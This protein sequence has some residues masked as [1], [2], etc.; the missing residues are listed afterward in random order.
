MT[1]NKGGRP[2][3][4]KSAQKKPVNASF[5]PRSAAILKKK[6]NT[7]AYLDE[8][9]LRDNMQQIRLNKQPLDLLGYLTALGTWRMVFQADPRATF[10][11]Q[12]GG[13][14]ETYLDLAALGTHILH[15]WRPLPVLHPW[16]GSTGFDGKAFEPLETIAGSK[17]NRLASYRKCIEVARRTKAATGV[18]GKPDSKPPTKSAESR[19]EKHILLEAL[20][21]KMPDAYLEWLDAVVNLTDDGPLYNPILGTGGNIGRLDIQRRYM[22]SLLLVMDPETGGAT[23][24]AEGWL[25]HALEGTNAR[26]LPVGSM[27][28]YSPS[29]GTENHNPW[30][31]LMLCE[32][33]VMLGAAAQ[34]RYSALPSYAAP[35][36][37]PWIVDYNGAGT[38]HA[39]SEGEA[40]PWLPC[41]LEHLSAPQAAHVL[42]EGYAL[43]PAGKHPRDGVGFAM[44]A[45]SGKLEPGLDGLRRGGN[46]FL[47]VGIVPNGQARNAVTFSEPQFTF[48]GLETD[49]EKALQAHIKSE[50]ERIYRVALGYGLEDTE[51]RDA[52]S[53]AIPEFRTPVAHV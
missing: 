14:I 31:W 10:S 12:E 29:T 9:V 39:L 26:G 3:K 34:R 7:S 37:F 20:R 38:H 19:S 47:R 49:W 24:R 13:I 52:A 21:G 48:P 45:A 50:W 53:R 44:T 5:S 46:A 28:Q 22:E 23:A 42:G 2:K 30:H 11:W 1:K 36:P 41:W 8:L 40:E 4:P 33:A 6:N 51:A 18:E 43:T 25:H 16:N 17:A 32:G 35:E 15:D 27:G